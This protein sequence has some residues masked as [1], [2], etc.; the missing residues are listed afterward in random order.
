MSATKTSSCRQGCKV[1][2]VSV[3]VLALVVSVATGACAADERAAAVARQPNSAV[4]TGETRYLIFAIE[5]E[6]LYE[7]SDRDTF[8]LIDERVGKLIERIGT[9]GNDDVKLGFSFLIPVWMIDSAYPGRVQAVVRDAF[10]VARARNIA[11]H[12]SIE[13]HYLWETRRDLWQ[14]KSNIEWIDWDRTPAPH[15]Y[16]DWGSPMKLAPHM[17]YNCPKIRAEVSRLVSK[18]VGPAIR[19]GLAEVPAGLFAGVTV[20][21]EPSL[22]DYTDV[23]RINPRLARLMERERAAKTRLGYNALTQAGY[24]KNN[25]PADFHEALAKINQEFIALWA[26]S[27]VDA[28]IPKN[29]LYT[30]V[31]AA[32]HGTP[33][34]KFLNAPLWVAFNDHS[35]PGF[36]TYPDGALKDDFAIIYRELE[37]HGN[38]PWGGTEANPVAGNHLVPMRE[39]LARHFEHG[40]TIIV[41][42]SGATSAEL[43]A[44]LTKGM[45][46]EAAVAAYREA[47]GAPRAAAVGEPAVAKPSEAR[48]SPPTGMEARI[49]GKIQSVHSRLQQL[50]QQGRDPAPYQREMREV[51]ALLR[52]GRPTDAERRL[53][54]I[55]G[56]LKAALGEPAEARSSPPTTMEA[57]IEG[58]IRSA[59]SQIQQLAQQGGDPTPYLREM[60]EV[61]ELLRA[62]RAADAERRLD[63]ILAKLKQK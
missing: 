7:A 59:Q 61:E 25:P 55:L 14:D 52:A 39:Y 10:R 57:R 62:G 35:R 31:A 48:S 12:F 28:G 46:S 5:T 53:D 42:N 36:T 26:K 60:R 32:A 38:P 19:D 63:D 56:K 49:E 9:V 47:L 51:E 27:F 33:M 17:C 40:A 8:A 24:S 1:R 43:T 11:V 44:T 22:D 50:A 18:V 37:R 15:R 3:L 29:R 23:D 54:D 2:A 4:P 20:G 30:H 41:M 58:K 6:R 13:T 16:L 45:W 34:E 21:S